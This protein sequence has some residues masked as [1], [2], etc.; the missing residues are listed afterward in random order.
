MSQYIP[1]AVRQ[2]VRV[3]ARNRCGYCLLPQHLLPFE[4]EIEHLLPTK[5]GGAN[6]EENLWRPAVPAT[7]TKA[8][9]H[10]PKTPFPGGVFAY[11]TRAAKDGAG[12]SN[13]ATTARASLA[14][15]EQAALLWKY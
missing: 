7:L 14:Q 13:G 11:S 12:T 9:K 1:E 3:A 15:Q 8:H 6:D 5:H 2:R 10:T 4:L